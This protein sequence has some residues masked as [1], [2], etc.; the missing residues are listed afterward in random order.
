MLK[1]CRV[2][3]QYHIFHRHIL[4]YCKWL[5]SEVITGWIRNL[6]FAISFMRLEATPTSPSPAHRCL[7]K[8]QPRTGFSLIKVSYK[9]INGGENSGY[10]RSCIIFLSVCDLA[11]C[12][13]S[14]LLVWSV[15]LNVLSGWCCH[16]ALGAIVRVMTCS[17]GGAL[18]LTGCCTRTQAMTLERTYKTPCIMFISH[19]KDGWSNKVYTL[20]KYIYIYF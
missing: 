5:V 7:I 9:N 11:I 18:R 14:M 15:R 10:K 4:G 8:L 3:N 17:H 20:K 6:R 2:H 12:P 19:T 13:L 1:A 16:E